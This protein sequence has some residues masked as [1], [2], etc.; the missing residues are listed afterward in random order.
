[1][2]TEID[3][4][5]ICYNNSNCSNN[6][7]VKCSGYIINKCCRNQQYECDKYFCNYHFVTIDDGSN[8]KAVCKDCYDSYHKQEKSKISYI[9]KNIKL[10][11]KDY[12]IIFISSFTIIYGVIGLI[13]FG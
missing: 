9:M 13:I 1:M 10:E 7:N 11:K 12:L 8:H 5:K 2:N 4:Q 3:I 6:P